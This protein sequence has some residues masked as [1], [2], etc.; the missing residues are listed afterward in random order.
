MPMV[1][2][3]P[4]QI[5][6][7]PLLPLRVI[8]FAGVALLLLVLVV[9]LVA[10]CILNRCMFHPGQAT[11]TA[12]DPNLTLLSDPAGD[13]AAFWIPRPE[14]RLALLYLH[15]NAEDLGD[16]L[17]V[18]NGFSEYGLSV[19]AVDY[20]GYGLS[21][22]KPSER[23]VY[24]AAETAYRFLTDEKH[25]AP[26]DVS[27]LGFSIGT[28]PA[29]YLAERHPVRALV[30]QSG[31]TSAPRT[32]TR[33]RLLLPDPFPNIAR[34]RNVKCPKLFLHG[35]DDKIVPYALGFKVYEAAKE[36][37]LFTG[38]PGAGHTR[39]QE[40]MPPGAYVDAVGSFIR[41]A[42]STPDA[43]NPTPQNRPETC[44]GH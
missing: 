38:V 5:A 10:V 14:T 43:Q 36:P 26:G 9:N 13:I 27:V 29:C 11:Y 32:R 40:G 44:H 7:L 4:H 33:I 12:H 42:T 19:L 37:K 28:G 24:R 23:E 18:L 22:G 8:A 31:F 30:F 39:L 20:P 35:T 3:M 17:P 41:R 25:F 2:C 16:I 15:G 1:F 6:A 34:I 21:P